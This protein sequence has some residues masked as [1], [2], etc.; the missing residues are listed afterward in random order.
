MKLTDSQLKHIRFHMDGLVARVRYLR[1]RRYVPAPPDEE[2]HLLFTDPDDYEVEEDRLVDYHLAILRGIAMGLD[3]D[4]PSDLYQMYVEGLDE[5]RVPDVAVLV[6]A[7]ER[8]LARLAENPYD[9]DRGVVNELGAALAP[10]K[11]RE[12]R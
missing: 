6:V 3:L 7:S 5:H 10:F 1:D 4:C 12:W 11:G 9:K 8:A 2:L